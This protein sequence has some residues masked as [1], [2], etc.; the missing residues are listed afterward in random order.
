MDVRMTFGR[1]WSPK[2]SMRRPFAGCRV[3]ATGR[4][5][6]DSEHAAQYRQVRNAPSEASR[7]AADDGFESGHD[8]QWQRRLEVADTHES[9]HTRE[10]RG[11]QQARQLTIGVFAQVKAPRHV[12]DSA[13]DVVRPV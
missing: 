5:E 11:A 3:S 12:V 1:S 13:R 6:L 4:D 2:C 10:T 8:A 7:Q 9:L